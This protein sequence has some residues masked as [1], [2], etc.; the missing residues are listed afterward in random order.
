MKQLRDSLLLGLLT[1]APL[2]VTL[3]V[4]VSVI[5]TL[6]HLF[7]SAIPFIKEP[8]DVFGVY[9]P[10]VGIVATFLLLWITGIFARTV[11]GDLFSKSWDRLMSRVPFLRG[12]YGIVK[13]MSQVFF[14]GDS[15]N[16]FQRVVRVPY[17]SASSSTLAFVAN[18][19]SASET[20]CFVPTAPNPPSGY[21]LIFKNSDIQE[22]SLT[23]EEALQLVVSCGA[24]VP[25]DR[26]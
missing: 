18:N 24:I 9:I 17:P 25:N 26:Q 6:D 16:S 20:L 13:Q 10:G 4:L 19:Y 2:A 8:R 21:V 5:Q 1:L 15:K 11:T 14:S 12:I 7:Y 23:V 22:S 3:W